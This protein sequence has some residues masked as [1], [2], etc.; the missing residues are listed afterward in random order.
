MSE[1]ELYEIAQ[2]RIDKRNRRWTWW[3]IHLTVLIAYIALFLGLVRTDYGIPALL[4]LI[5][6]GGVFTLHSILLAMAE[7]REKDIEKEVA[8]LRD[9]LYEKPK[10]LELAE[11]G[12]LVE[13][14][15]EDYAARQQNR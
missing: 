15:D 8:R 4:G 3:A 2:Q 7:S 5:A 11:D 6:W 9:A 10:R 12:E 14:Q 13:V 1:T